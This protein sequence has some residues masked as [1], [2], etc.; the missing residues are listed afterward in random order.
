[1]KTWQDLEGYFDFADLYDKQ[2]EI[3]RDGAI[4]VELG[5]WNGRSFVY[6]AEAIKKSG[7]KIDLHGVDNFQTPPLE[8]F[9]LNLLD[10]GV[11]NATVTKSDS[12]EAAK[13]YKD[14]SV[15]F[16]FIDADHSYQA[17]KKDI[18]A[19]LPKIR[20]GGF[21]G[22]HDI[23]RTVVYHAVQDALE[24]FQRVGIN[25]WLKEVTT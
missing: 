25:S 15:D 13:L 7:K 2:V 8:Q 20:K 11:L 21:I 14:K 19:W 22:G 24:N 9:M 1:M 23:Q 6:L 16:V 10:C 5:L 17:V 18:F 4:F 12:A 3:A